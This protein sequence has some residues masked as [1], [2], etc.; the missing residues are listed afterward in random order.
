MTAHETRP[1]TIRTAP[2]TTWDASG[3]G[4]AVTAPSQPPGRAPARGQPCILSSFRLL[5]RPTITSRQSPNRYRARKVSHMTMATRVCRASGRHALHRASGRTEGAISR[6]MVQAVPF[7]RNPSGGDGLDS[8]REEEAKRGEPAHAAPRGV[9]AAGPPQQS[10]VSEAVMSYLLRTPRISE[11]LAATV[12]LPRI[13][14]IGPP[15]RITRRTGTTGEDGPVDDVGMALRREGGHA[16]AVMCTS[17]PRAGAAAQC[18]Y[19]REPG[20]T[21]SRVPLT[22]AKS[23]FDRVASSH[24]PVPGVCSPWHGGPEERT[25]ALPGRLPTGSARR[26]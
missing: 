7:R 3:H 19:G 18:A 13:R 23:E 26:R 1:G 25:K 11:R 4:E 5:N 16:T 8:T 17:P 10:P 22:D 20:P 15:P 21:V 2:E 12:R 24:L 14:R 6:R 9:R